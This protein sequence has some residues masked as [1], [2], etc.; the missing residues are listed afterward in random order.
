MQS[1]SNFMSTVFKAA[2]SIKF[3][4]NNFTFLKK[5]MENYFLKMNIIILYPCIKQT[6]ILLNESHANY[7]FLFKY[8]TI[9]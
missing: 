1:S 8:F 7:D 4:F 3:I 5:N 2:F 9:F 6:T